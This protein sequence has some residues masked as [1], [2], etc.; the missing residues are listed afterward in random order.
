[1]PVAAINCDNSETTCHLSLHS[2]VNP[3]AEISDVF[4]ALATDIL[5]NNV[6]DARQLIRWGETDFVNTQ[7]LLLVTV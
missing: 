5:Q 2:L 3:S 7:Y 1:M 6:K 4:G